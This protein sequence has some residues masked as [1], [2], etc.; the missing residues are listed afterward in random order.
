MRFIGLLMVAG[1]IGF[2]HSAEA[3]EWE[4]HE[5]HAVKG[6]GTN[7]PKLV[8]SDTDAQDLDE[9][10]DLC[11]EVCASEEGD[12]P[13]G[14]CGGFVVNYTDR[15][16]TAPRLCVFK[17]VGSVPYARKGKDT[18]MLVDAATASEPEE[19]DGGG[20]SHVEFRR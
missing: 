1:V 3:Q 20:T 9:F 19:V 8:F 5:G 2:C 17:L 13:Q 10:V 4:V 7:A 12:G 14:A 15:A 6:N 16:K 18:H 11:R